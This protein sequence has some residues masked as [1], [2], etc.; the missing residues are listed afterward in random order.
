MKLFRQMRGVGSLTGSLRGSLESRV[1]TLRG[2]GSGRRA[3]E[4][5]FPRV[6]LRRCCGTPRY[7]ERATSWTELDLRRR[8]GCEPCLQSLVTDEWTPETN[9]HLG[10][11]DSCRTA[12]FALGPGVRVAE[13]TAPAAARSGWSSRRRRG[14]RAARASQVVDNP[15]GGAAACAAAGARGGAGETA[16]RALRRRAGTKGPPARRAP[17]ARSRGAA[18]SAPSSAAARPAA[19][20]AAQALHA[21]RR[22]AA[23]APATT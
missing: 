14:R 18:R 16:R 1:N 19:P 20:S 17:T 9:H 6:G 2:G 8:P 7:R 3:G 21:S 12:A 15:F 5:R 13:R 22:A 10:W 11:C 4:R 23:R